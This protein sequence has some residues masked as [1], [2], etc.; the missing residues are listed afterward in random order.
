MASRSQTFKSADHDWILTHFFI[1][2]KTDASVEQVV[3]AMRCNGQYKLTDPRVTVYASTETHKQIERL[4]YNNMVYI[5]GTKTLFDLKEKSTRDAIEN[6]P[7]IKTNQHGTKFS[8]RQGIDDTF[9]ESVQDHGSTRDFNKAKDWAS[10]LAQYNGCKGYCYV[11]PHQFMISREEIVSIATK[12]LNGW[13]LRKRFMTATDFT[14]ISA[15]SQ[16]L[17]RCWIIQ[18]VQGFVPG[19]RK[20]NVAYEKNRAAVLN[21]LHHIKD[22]NFQ[23]QIVAEIH[24]NGNINV[25]VYDNNYFLHPESYDNTVLIW[26]DTGGTFHLYVNKHN[27]DYVFVNLHH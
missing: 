8:S 1:D 23:S 21:R 14:G 19:V 26:V 15:S 9:T 11:T 18:K 17:L 12:D 20:C 16:K 22:I 6:I 7:F 5:A 2:V 25:V 27:P 4:L 13:E 24:P 10:Y 3:Q